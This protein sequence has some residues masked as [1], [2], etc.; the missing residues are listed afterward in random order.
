MQVAK[1]RLLV[2]L[3]ND[4]TPKEIKEILNLLSLID[5]EESDVN[6]LSLTD[7]IFQSNKLTRNKFSVIKIGWFKKLY[8][9]TATLGTRT[10]TCLHDVRTRVLS[11]CT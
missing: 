10:R 4:K 3:I 2:S 9:E 5:F 8:G 11:T 6:P 1:A 7:F